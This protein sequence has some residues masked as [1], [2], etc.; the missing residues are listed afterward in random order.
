MALATVAS[1]IRTLD[2]PFTSITDVQE[3]KEEQLVALANKTVSEDDADTV[4]GAHIS[5]I[6]SYRHFLM[7]CFEAHVVSSFSDV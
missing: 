6:L 2:E 7:L 4:R 5:T 3:E 1:S